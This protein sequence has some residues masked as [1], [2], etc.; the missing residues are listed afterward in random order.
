MTEGVLFSEEMALSISKECMER[1]AC[2]MSN[3]PYTKTIT[4]DQMQRAFAAGIAKITS[5]KTPEQG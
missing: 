4:L 2:H 1:V 5:P 3:L